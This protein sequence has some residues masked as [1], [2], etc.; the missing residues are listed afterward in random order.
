[1]EIIKSWELLKNGFNGMSGLVFMMIKDVSKHFIKT[2]DTVTA[3]GLEEVL[4]I[5]SKNLYISQEQ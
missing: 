2:I 3:V 1:M 5:K 4:L